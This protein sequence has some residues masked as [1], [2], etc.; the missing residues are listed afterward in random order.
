MK[1]RDFITKTLADI[2]AGLG[3]HTSGP[4]HFEVALEADTENVLIS[5]SAA[6]PTVVP[7][8]IFDVSP[9]PR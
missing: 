3:R 7:R 9:P 8:I 1:L 6:S 4:I 2:E 5:D